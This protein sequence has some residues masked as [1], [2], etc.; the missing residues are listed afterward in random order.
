MRICHV[1]IIPF[2]GILIFFTVL[3]GSASPT[4]VQEPSEIPAQ[5]FSADPL[6][7]TY[8][9][10]GRTI[11][12]QDGRSEI[13]ITPHSA[14]TIKTVVYGKPVYGDLDGDG[15]RDTAILLIHDPGGSGRF[16]YVAGALIING[17][18]RGTNAV[19]LGDRITPPDLQIRNG[20]LIARYADRG[21]GEPMVTTPT[22]QMAKYLILKDAQLESILPIEE[23]EQVIEGWV[24]IGHEV[25]SF[26][27]CLQKKEHWLQGD[28]PALR[29]IMVA[30]DEAMPKPKL[31]LPLFMILAGKTAMPPIQGFG[32]E[33]E[34]AFLATQLVRIMPGGTCSSDG[35]ATDSSEI[36]EDLEFTMRGHEKLTFDVSIL[37]P[38]GLYGEPDGKRALTYEFCIP[39]MERF[40]SK[41][42][43]IDATLQCLSETPGRIGCD[44]HE[45]LCIGSTHQPRFREVLRDLA[46]LPSITRIDQSFLE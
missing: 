18:L 1:E 25:R 37:D 2:A 46:E 31:Y 29:Q 17:T 28:S 21:H 8:S 7:A 41:V 32:A 22:V 30:Y 42:K 5:E 44:S 27:P 13:S 38:N 9:I 34:S 19:L 6:N 43:Q 12:L 11:R 16:F 39:G 3:I 24:T 35:H 20:I 26:K 33:Y 40:L 15:H 10:E 4:T 45:F 14:T 23:G 36:R